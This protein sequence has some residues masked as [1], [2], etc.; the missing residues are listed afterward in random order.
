M[1][2]RPHLIA[3]AALIAATAAHA[4]TFNFSGLI[5]AGPL[6]GQT[7]GGSYS[8]DPSLV[9]GAAFEQIELSAFTLSFSAVNYTLNASATADYADGVFLGLNYLFEDGA[10]QLVMVS[11]SAD[12]SDA[13]LSYQPL[14]D[15]E[16]TP[17]ASSGLY[18]VSA[19]PE[20]G[21]YALMIGG[22]GLVGWMARRRKA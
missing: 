22:L 18:S 17:T 5:D 7:F 12:A 2:F 20:P 19:V 14:L 1:K 21:T 16:P 4:D 8:Y 10:H 6:A 15:G 13:F 3:A 11:G 9:T